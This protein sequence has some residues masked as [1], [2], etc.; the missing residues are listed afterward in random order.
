MSGFRYGSLGAYTYITPG[1]S[2]VV[3]LCSVLSRGVLS[4]GHPLV[5]RYLRVRARWHYK[6]GHLVIRP[7]P[8]CEKL[9]FTGR[10]PETK[11]AQ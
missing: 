5:L 1:T 9:S 11:S 3:L 7:V 8:G 6:P 4:R 10:K 2:L